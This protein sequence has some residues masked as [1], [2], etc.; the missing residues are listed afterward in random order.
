MSHYLNRTAHT[1]LIDVDVAV[2]VVQAWH[3][4]VKMSVCS[5]PW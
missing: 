3:G 4:P 2:F 1:A 5:V